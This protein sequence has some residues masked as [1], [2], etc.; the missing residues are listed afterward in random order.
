MPMPT[1]P[2]RILRVLHRAP[3]FSAAVLVLVA[4]AVLVNASAF[5]AIHALRWKALPYR[6]GGQ[7]VELRANLRSFG[8]EVGLTER[9]RGEV[10]A[11]RA[12]FAGVLGFTKARGNG[13]DGRAWRI[14]R[15]TGG[16]S[17][18]LG[19]QPALGRGL[20]DDDARAGADAVLVISDAIWRERFGGDPGVIGRALR[21]SDRVYTIIGVMPRG[22]AFPDATTEAWRPYVM[23]DD[24]RDQSERGN[25]GG[26]DVLARLAPGVTVAQ[27][28]AAMA[29]IIARDAR[30]A[31]LRDSANVTGDARPW[32]DRYA[33]AHWQALA[34]F[35]FAALI[36]LAVV[37]ANLMNLQLD[38]L[39]ARLREFDI[40]RA[41]GA[42]ERAILRAVLADL[43][44]P[45]VTGLA[46]GLVAT[47]FVTALL[48]RRGLLPDDLPQGTGFGA[49]TLAAGL[50]VAALA[51]A[52]GALAA[53]VSRHAARLST[54]ASVAGL[55]RLRPA[56]LIAQVMLTTA[57]IGSTALLLR[58]AVNLLDSDRGFDANGVL[59]SLI[60][61][62][63]VSLGDRH[64]DPAT[65][66]ATLRP[67]VE[68]IRAAVA[69]LPGVDRAAVSTMPPFTG[70]EAVSSFRV[71]G[72][73][74]L[75]Q[76]RGRGVGPGYFAALG[77]GLVAGREFRA[78]DANESAPV[79]VDALYR[80]RYLQGRDPIGASVEVPIGQNRHRQATIVGVARTVK[81]EALDEMPNLPTIYQIDEAP[82]PVFWLVT[83][84][85]GDVVALAET[86]RQRVRELLPGA[87]V[88]INKPLD[89]LVAETMTSR[90]A[91][92]EA[93][94]GFAAGTLL[95]A[96][97]GLA[98]MLSFA[99]RRRTA[100]LGVRMALGATPARVRNLVLRQGSALIVAGLLLGAAIGL[101]SARLLADRLFGIG[102]ADPTS[103]GSA[104]AVVAVV[105]LFACWLPAR[106]A[107]ATGPI[108]ALRH[109]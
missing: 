85:R 30:L 55:G 93:L 80:D 34:L 7:L 32:R 49:A 78:G 92:V 24:E 23:T 50:A 15:V 45:V 12:H 14:A 33:A 70:W 16:F 95:L 31:D 10:E 36:L 79:I 71:P 90:R 19:V 89:D 75:V 37:T 2:L 94:G 101:A 6:D 22:F 44:P 53:F 43:A 67:T 82:L 74:D 18:V 59:L 9:L 106:R 11:D 72:Q 91:L 17:P 57:L 26:L 86:V 83:H 4:A 47:P 5:G 8:F 97:V 38:R 27:A 84:T 105:A 56:L 100:E 39:L 62:M 28:D 109:E 21:F 99:I 52:S 66:A 46:L 20:A 40:R 35:Q 1:N 76:A 60:D 96:G 102:F 65:D 98:A 51:L 104:L 58:S 87:D 103:W 63:G 108:E 29:A 69:A 54:R 3:M 61:P 64:Y 41:I 88:G 25:V 77:I 107:A 68:S 73:T 42:D 48:A 81:H 13:E